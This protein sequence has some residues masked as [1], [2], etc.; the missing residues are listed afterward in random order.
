MATYTI[1]LRTFVDTRIAGIVSN[2]F[3][4][5]SGSGSFQGELGAVGN[6]ISLVLGHG[7][8][9]MNQEG[10]GMGIVGGYEIHLGI[11]KGCNEVKIS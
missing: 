9:N 11:H 1:P 3:L 6:H 2:Y 10:G 8:Q 5:P 4:V 7:H